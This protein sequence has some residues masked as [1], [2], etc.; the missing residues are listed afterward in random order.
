VSAVAAIRYQAVAVR[1]FRGT[2]VGAVL[3]IL[4]LPSVLVL[5]LSFSDDAFIKF[6]PLSWGVKHYTSVFNSTVLMP[7]LER[8]L[9]L[10]AVVAPVSI[11]FGGLLAFGFYRTRLKQSPW[12]DLLVLGPILVPGLTYALAL[13]SLYASIGLLGTKIGLVIAHTLIALPFVT[14]IIGAALQRI[15]VELEQAA[16][17]LGAGRWRTYRKIT[18]R[19]LAPG[20][21]TAFIFAFLASFDEAVFVSFLAGPSFTTLQLEIFHSLQFGLDPAI[22]A[23]AALLTA[24]TALAIGL[25]ALIQRLT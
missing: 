17:S 1:G 19:L 4:A 6:P 20:I 14:L 24:V 21:A 16:L 9:A 3:V 8:S 12:V 10:A 13:Y 2:I 25:S 7:A 5:I 15:P 11:L 22:T 23:I 18:L